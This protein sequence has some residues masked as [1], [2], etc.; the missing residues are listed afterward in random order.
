MNIHEDVL[1]LMPTSREMQFPAMSALQAYVNLFQ[2]KMTNNNYIVGDTPVFSLRYWCDMSDE[3]WQFFQ[4][5]GIDLKQD[6]EP[7]QSPDAVVDLSLQRLLAFDVPGGIKHC[8][9]ICSAI[10]GVEAPPF[11]KVR[12]RK[13]DPLMKRIVTVQ[14]IAGAEVISR[15]EFMNLPDGVI[16]ALVGYRGWETYMAAAQGLPVIEVLPQGCNPAWLSKW[17]NPFYRAV[18]ADGSMD[19]L[20]QA[21]LANLRGILRW[22]YERDRALAAKGIK[23]DHSMSSAP[24]A[25]STSDL[26][27]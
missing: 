21:A 7:I 1:F 22:L 2:T 26:V 14:S 20:I 12:P 13:P 9:Q 15:E 17:S 10:A 27:P 23:T 19:E 8:A 25:V 3:D 18:E 11:P 16:G 4:S 6:R 24:L 5:L